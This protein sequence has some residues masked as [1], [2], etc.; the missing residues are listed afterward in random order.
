MATTPLEVKRF[1][2]WAA[3]R[4]PPRTP[5]GSC[6]LPAR[7]VG[8]NVKRN[9][10][11][12]AVFALAIGMALAGLALAT[13]GASIVTAEFGRKTVPHFKAR[14]GEGDIVIS[15]IS[16]APGGYSG[17][18]SHP[19]KV[20]GA[21]QR[22]ALTLYRSD[23]PTCTGHT[24]TAGQIFTEIPSVSYYGRDEGTTATVL[25]VTF[26]NVPVGGSV[27]IDQPAPGNCPF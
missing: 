17:W 11:I 8:G 27:R 5:V 15:E 19:G 21:V 12:L 1:R 13:P 22:G 26:F 4:G 24:Y 14:M 3:P 10:M 7:Q 6:E 23:D 9:L 18:H 2:P 16:L 20:V 25:D